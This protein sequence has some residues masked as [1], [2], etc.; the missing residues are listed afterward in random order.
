MCSVRFKV[1]ELLASF[2]IEREREQSVFFF[3]RERKLRIRTSQE[4]QLQHGT[5]TPNNV[6]LPAEKSLLSRR[7]SF[8]FFHHIAKMK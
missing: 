4:R 1:G 6:N 3:E 8:F 7:Y 2:G 5:F